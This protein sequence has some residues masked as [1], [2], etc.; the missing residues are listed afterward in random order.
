MKHVKTFSL[1]E[2]ET[3]LTKKQIDFL[4]KC[5][6]GRWWLNPTTGLVDIDGDFDCIDSKLKNLLGV[7]FGRVSG[8]FYCHLN[9]LTTLEGAPLEV[10][11]DFN[12]TN[13]KLTTLEGAP[14]K[15]GGNFLCFWNELTSLKGAPEEVGGDFNCHLNQLSTLEGAPREVDGNFFCHDNKLTTLKEAPQKVGGGFKCYYNELT[16]LEGAPLEV[17]EYFYL[18]PGSRFRWTTKGKLEFMR[19]NPKWAP[20]IAPTLPYDSLVA[21]V[22]EDPTLLKQ[23]EDFDKVL[24]NRV[25]KGLGWDKMGPDLLRQL[26]DGIL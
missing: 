22:S 6:I 16:T 12:C 20:L 26:K 7:K 21:S 24:Y 18:V 2:S 10:G 19:E 3:T 5:T 8:S 9:Q 17:G 1:F 14:Q 4:E 25:L 11:R 13:N 23:I 15:V